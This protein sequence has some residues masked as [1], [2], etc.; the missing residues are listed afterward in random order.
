MHSTIHKPGDPEF[1]DA[2]ELSPSQQYQRQN[3]TLQQLHCPKPSARGRNLFMQRCC[4]TT[5]AVEPQSKTHNVSSQ[6]LLRQLLKRRDKLLTHAQSWMAYLMW[7]SRCFINIIQTQILFKPSKKK[8]LLCES[9]LWF[10]R[11]E[12]MKWV[13]TSTN[14]LLP[15]CSDRSE[16]SWTTP[17]ATSRAP[18][19]STSK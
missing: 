16:E 8:P 19:H 13:L 11:T 6:T 10:T 14:H 3:P 9:E 17:E 15:T 4:Q 1:L 5:R 2:Q 12:A 7:T 18:Q